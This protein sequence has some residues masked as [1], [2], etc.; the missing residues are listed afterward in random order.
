MTFSPGRQLERL[1]IREAPRQRGSGACG[2]SQDGW[3]KQGPDVAG[4]EGK[5]W[6]RPGQEVCDLPRAQNVSSPVT[7]RDRNSEMGLQ[8]GVTLSG[9]RAETRALHQA[10]TSLPPG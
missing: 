10:E 9:T 2:S 3:E 6:G 7:S 5:V 1:P 8:L 4:F